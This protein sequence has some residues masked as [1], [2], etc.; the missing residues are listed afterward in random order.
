ML[1]ITSSFV[2]FGWLPDGIKPGAIRLFL[3]LAGFSPQPSQARCVCVSIIGDSNL[4][5][6]A[7][8]SA[9]MDWQPVLN[10]FPRT[11][12]RKPIVTFISHDQRWTEDRQMERSGDIL[13]YFYRGA[14][15]T[16]WNEYT[17]RQ[18]YHQIL[19]FSLTCSS[20][21]SWRLTINISSHTHIDL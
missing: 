4:P 11:H 18:R 15:V 1:E 10:V 2:I 6:G 9:V 7:T 21:V 8:V 13:I 3:C 5:R 20:L 12:S 16:F 19:L 17:T 14:V